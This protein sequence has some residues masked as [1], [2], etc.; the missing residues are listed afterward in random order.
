MND[1]SARFFVD[2]KNNCSQNYTTYCKLLDLSL[3]FPSSILKHVTLV[4]KKLPECIDHSKF[5][6]KHLIQ[7]A[8]VR[9]FL[10]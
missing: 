1:I 8:R 10:V 4:N 6:Y 9:D 3:F 5:C 2:K 7:L